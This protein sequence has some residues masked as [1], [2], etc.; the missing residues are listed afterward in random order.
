MTAIP[1]LQPAT[2]K[3]ALPVRR[4]AE[5]FT[6][7]ALGEL[8]EPMFGTTDESGGFFGGGTAEA[9][10][11]P[12]L[13]QEIAKSLAHRGGLGLTDAIERQLLALQERAS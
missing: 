13:T 11:R 4:Q 12:M 8:L 1:A 3:D 6:A 5:D 10:W 2:P 7:V 9:T